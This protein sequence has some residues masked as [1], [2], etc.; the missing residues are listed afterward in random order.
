MHP[1]LRFL[2]ISIIFSVCS[3]MSPVS[4]APAAYQGSHL[5]IY[6]DQQVYMAGLTQF[7][8]DVDAGRF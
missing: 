3:M 5:A 1:L 8:L 7:I 2:L 4:A 6:D